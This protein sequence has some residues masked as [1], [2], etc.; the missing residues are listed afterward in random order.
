MR[1]ALATRWAALA[2][3]VACGGPPSPVVASRPAASSVAAPARATAAPAARP[4][5][6]APEPW[7]DDD[8]A[9]AIALGKQTHRPVV[10]DAWA[11]WCHTCRSMRAYVLED[12][13]LPRS[14]FV[15]LSMDVENPKNEAACGKLPVKVLPTFF[16]VDPA[17]ES[18][19]GRWEGAASVAQMRAFLAD[20]ER[21]VQSAHTSELPHDDALALLRDADRLGLA[22]RFAAAA[23]GYAA[24]IAKAPGGWARLPDALVSRIDALE[25]AGD[26]G[27]CADLGL[28]S[29]GDTG[30]SS[31]CT[32]FATTAV[33]CAAHLKKEDPRAKRLFGVVEA[34]MKAL[35]ADASAPLSADDRGDAMRLLWDVQDRLGDHD[36]AVST[37]KARLAL[38]EAAAARAPDP[39]IATTYDGA[40]LETLL[41]LGRPA[42]AVRFLEPREKELP[43]DYNVPHRLAKA[44]LEAKRPKDA[45]AAADRA[46]KLAYG[47]RKGLIYALRADILLALG[48]KK[49]ARKAVEDQLALYRSLPPGQRRPAYEKVAADRL[50]RMKAGKDPSR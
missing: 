31:S 20:A 2:A 39:A 30:S 41:Y 21:S 23:R 24:A 19:H 29:L 50:A 15:W 6:A 7:V 36:G 49:E 42:D 18:V 17:D 40:R 46:L 25:R 22:G 13:G 35:V 27:A 3:L 16:V 28:A 12:A 4:A 10:I 38:V 48:R 47:P 26:D 1:H 14:R 11:T 5:A 34:R 37:A 45:L 8:Y 9:R 33:E 44:Y 43:D 32:D